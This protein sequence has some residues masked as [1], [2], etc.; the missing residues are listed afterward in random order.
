M[1]LSLS[2][3]SGHTALFFICREKAKG[4]VMQLVIWGSVSG[5]LLD[6]LDIFS[7]VEELVRFLMIQFLFI[8]GFPDRQLL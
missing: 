5:F 8:S 2:T 3:N 1:D 6:S 7:C 4:S